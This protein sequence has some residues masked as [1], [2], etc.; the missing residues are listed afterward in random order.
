MKREETLKSRPPCDVCG[1]SATSSCID[2]VEIDNY[3]TQFMEF[4]REGPVRHGC[5]DHPVYSQTLWR[6]TKGLWPL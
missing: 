4:R 2:V 1:K 3:E 6:E 5:D